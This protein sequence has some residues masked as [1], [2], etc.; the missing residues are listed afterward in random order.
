MPPRSKTIAPRGKALPTS[1]PKPAQADGE[2][3]RGGWVDRNGRRCNPPPTRNKRAGEPVSVLR[4]G[5]RDGIVYY[6]ADVEL[7]LRLIAEGH[8]PGPFGYEPTRGREWA[9]EANVEAQVWLWKGA[10]T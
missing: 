9:D 8:S 4:G 7:L 6:T 10:G 2:P 1:A 5:P 3:E